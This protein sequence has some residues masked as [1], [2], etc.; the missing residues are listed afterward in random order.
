MRRHVSFTAALLLLLALSLS[1]AHDGAAEVDAYGE[2]GEVDEEQA[3][4]TVGL[5]FDD[6]YDPAVGKDA[7]WGVDRLFLFARA[8][9]VS[10]SGKP[11][12]PR[13]QLPRLIVVTYTL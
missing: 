8:V 12:G 1:F 2:D 4:N 9:Q 7:C 10:R 11:H 5:E 13:A 6:D 3:T